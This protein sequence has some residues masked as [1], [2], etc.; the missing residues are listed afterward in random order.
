LEHVGVIVKA[1]QERAHGIRAALVPAEARYHAVGGARVLYL[2][3]GA[4]AWLVSKP[5]GLGDD[6][7]EACAL[8]VLEPVLGLVALAGH[9]RDIHGRLAAAEQ[10]LERRA[11]RALR[12]AHEVAPADGERVEGNEGGGRLFGELGD[13]RGGRMQA[14]L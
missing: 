10:P 6:A 11:A 3:H 4:L 2:D 5:G 14:Q 13:A 8:E 12:L 9:R 1:E 7:V